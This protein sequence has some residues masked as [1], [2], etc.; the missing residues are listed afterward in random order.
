MLPTSVPVGKFSEL[1]KRYVWKLPPPTLVPISFLSICFVLFFLTGMQVPEVIMQFVEVTMQSLGFI[2]RVPEVI[3][4]ILEVKIQVI[5]GNRG[6]SWITLSYFYHS[7][8]LP[9]PPLSSCVIFWHTPLPPTRWCSLWTRKLHCLY[10]KPLNNRDTLCLVIIIIIP[11]IGF[12]VND[13]LEP[14]VSMQ[15]S[16]LLNLVLHFYHM[17]TKGWIF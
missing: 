1:N 13:R 12:M 17:Y 15:K 8:T 4:Q 2:I 14:S 6:C 10:Q 16:D 3:M 7:R 5:R 11:I 9:P